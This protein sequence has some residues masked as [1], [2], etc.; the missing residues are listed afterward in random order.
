MS[1]YYCHKCARELGIITAVDPSNLA[2]NQYQFDKFV[3][4]T[5]PEKFYPKNSVFLTSGLDNYKNYLV[6]G[7]NS[8]C[9]EINDDNQYNLIFFAG[10][11]TGLCFENDKF[12][13]PCSGIMVVLSDDSGHIH[14]FPSDFQPE[15]R[16]CVNC[17]KLVPFDPR[18]L[19]T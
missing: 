3:K 17:G 19:I 4:H 7:T 15:S 9:I 14:G 6:S 5:T 8:G 1:M 11:E 13:S 16:R 18:K 12:V 2:L 10:I